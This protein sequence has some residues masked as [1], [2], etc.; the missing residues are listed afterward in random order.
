MSDRDNFIARWSRRKRAAQEADATAPPAAPDTGVAPAPTGEGDR[1]RTDAA[2][3]P[4]GAPTAAEAPFDVASLPPIESIT[5]VSDIRAFLAPGVPAELT[6]AA[7]RRVWTADPTIRNFVGLA[8]YDWDFNTPGAM[9]GFGSLEMT[10]EL[11]RCVTEMVG[12][13]LRVGDGETPPPTPT[14]TAAAPPAVET[15]SESVATHEPTPTETAQ[16]RDGISQVQATAEHND[17]HNSS[18]IL[19]SNEEH[20]ASQH[21]LEKPDNV[22]LIAKRPHGRA[23]PK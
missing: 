12:R 11:R 14:T 9:A 15:S 17:R 21:D 3:L 4:S 19:H 18:S 20:T 10:D 1:A 2:A 16:S 7:L 22:Q 13:S 23:L 6:R 8:D 5:A